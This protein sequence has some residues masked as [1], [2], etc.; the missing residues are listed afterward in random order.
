MKKLIYFL[1]ATVLLSVMVS[2]CTQVD[3]PYETFDDLQKGAFPRTLNSSGEFNFFDPAGSQYDISVEFYDENN[4]QNVTSY[5]WTVEF[6]GALGNFP[7]TAFLSIP[8]SSFG[9]SPDNLPSTDLTLG[10]NAAMS[11]LG[12]TM[13]DVSGGDTFVFHATITKADGSTFDEDNTGANIFSSS[14]FAAMFTLRAN[15]VCPSSLEGMVDFTTT[16]AFGGG[17]TLSSTYELSALGSGQYEVLTLDGVSDMSWGGY[18]AGYG[19]GTLG[20]A[21]FWPEGNNKMVDACNKLGTAGADQWGDS[22]S[23]N[24][25]TV[26][27]DMKTLTL[28]WINTYGEGGVSILTYADGSDWPPLVQ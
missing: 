7:E 21:G 15:V 22:Y 24:S 12:M 26:S 6:T 14:T 20:S 9:T 11:A 13:A 27:A 17:A 28:D 10:M 16:A 1:S 19:D 8:S 4:G 23:Y 18:D 3:F 2:S 5:D 25:V